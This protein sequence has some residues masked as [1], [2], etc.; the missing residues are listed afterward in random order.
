M[1]ALVR[2]QQNIL[3]VENMKKKKFTRLK[4]SE[5]RVG[6]HLRVVQ[7]QRDGTEKL[8]DTVWE[9]VSLHEE[10]PYVVQVKEH[11]TEYAPHWSDVHLF[12][13]A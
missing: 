1:Q 3:A 12:T 8:D 11:N 6:D 2:T 5:A 9:V 7:K 13:R 4:P 10:V